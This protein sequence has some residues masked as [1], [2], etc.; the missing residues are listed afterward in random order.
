MAAGAGTGS[1]SASTAFRWSVTFSRSRKATAHSS[2]SANSAASGW[3]AVWPEAG[4]APPAAEIVDFDMGYSL[5]WVDEWRQRALR[6]SSLGRQDHRP[7]ARFAQAARA[8]RLAALMRMTVEM[9]TFSN[10]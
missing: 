6:V 7:A 9:M 10:A 2:A 1:N 3:S 8:S 5:R 4:I